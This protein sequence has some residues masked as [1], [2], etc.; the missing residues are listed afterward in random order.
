MGGE[1][2]EKQSNAEGRKPRL[3]LDFSVGFVY[4]GKAWNGFGEEALRECIQE[5]R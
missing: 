3:S 1:T 2:L 4:N 5:N